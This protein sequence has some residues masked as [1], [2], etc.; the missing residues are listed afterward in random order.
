MKSWLK[1]AVGGL[2]LFTL[3]VSNAL[4]AGPY[5][6]Y[7]LTPCRLV[8]TRQPA[9]PTGGPSLANGTVR[10]FPIAGLCGLPTTAQVA[11]LNVAA[12]APA[13]DGFMTF[14]AY[15]TQQPSA[16][17]INF[18]SAAFA[19]A[20]G[21]TVAISNPNPTANLS[22]FTSVGGYG[23]VDLVVDIVGYYQ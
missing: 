4:G 8:D 9:G 5:S 11:V 17:N 6:Y 12:I 1:L 20:N 13:G 10:S 2:L 22:V 23:L 15:G 7:P 21:A 3:E 14:F 16:S 19:V 18:T